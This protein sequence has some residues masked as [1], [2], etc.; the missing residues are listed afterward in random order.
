M[1]TCTGSVRDRN[2]KWF[3]SP[4]VENVSPSRF[5]SPF[6]AANLDG[7]SVDRQ[8]T[9]KFT[10]ITN[11]LRFRWQSE[12]R[13]PKGID[14]SVRLFVRASRRNCKQV[15]LS[16]VSTWS[17]YSGCNFIR[18]NI[19]RSDLWLS[20]WTL[21]WAPKT[22]KLWGTS[23]ALAWNDVFSSQAVRQ[24]EWIY[25]FNMGFKRR[26]MVSCERTKKKEI[27]IRDKT[28]FFVWIRL[29]FVGKGQSIGNYQNC[30]VNDN[31][32]NEDSFMMNINRTC[33]WWSV[34]SKLQ[35]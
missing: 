27:V 15:L 26:N 32:F 33:W 24:S 8:R 25:G 10:V 16:L 13:K 29:W 18:G 19:T 21:L 23:A 31:S 22:Q 34:G 1:R 12:Q 35:L 9:K 17:T 14:S 11:L 2:R 3:V 6:G 20:G 30:S 7:R 5:P 28:D 4:Y